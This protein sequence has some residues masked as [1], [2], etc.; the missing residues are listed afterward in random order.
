[1]ALSFASEHFE[2]AVSDLKDFAGVGR[3]CSEGKEVSPR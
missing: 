2:S 3:G 1:M